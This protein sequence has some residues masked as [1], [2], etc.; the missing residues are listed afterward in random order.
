MMVALFFA[1]PKSFRDTNYI[2]LGTYQTILYINMHANTQHDHPAANRKFDTCQMIDNFQ[3]RPRCN[4]AT[5]KFLDFHSYKTCR[6]SRLPCSFGPHSNNIF[7]ILFYIY[8]KKTFKK[9]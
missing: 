1:I 2:T 8:I 5:G 4:F 6:F 7:Y 3:I 9:K